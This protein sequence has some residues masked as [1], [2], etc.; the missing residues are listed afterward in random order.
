M[1]RPRWHDAAK[2]G[3]AKAAIESGHSFRNGYRNHLQMCDA[4]AA[5]DVD[6]ES[7]SAG[8]GAKLHVFVLAGRVCLKPRPRCQSLEHSAPHEKRASANPIARHD[9]PHHFVGKER[10]PIIATTF[11]AVFEV[12]VRQRGLATDSPAV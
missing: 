10:G 6:G 3:E 2:R 7:S 8:L 11:A 1:D 5:V 12:P 4:H 9:A